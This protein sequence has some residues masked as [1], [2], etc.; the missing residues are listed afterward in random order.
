M[1]TQVPF[2]AGKPGVIIADTLRGKGLPSLQ[3]KADR[4]FC[5]FSDREVKELL[6]ELHGNGHSYLTSEILTVR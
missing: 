6:N 2:E 1:F 5:N 3:A 4:W